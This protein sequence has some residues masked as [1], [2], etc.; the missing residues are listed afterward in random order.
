VPTFPIPAGF[1][2]GAKVTRTHGNFGDV[3]TDEVVARVTKTQVITNLGDRFVATRDTAE[4]GSLRL[5]G[6][7]GNSFSILRIAPDQP[8][9]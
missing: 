3:I 7:K 8:G 2:P 4:T 6:A 9:N 1:V 5:Y